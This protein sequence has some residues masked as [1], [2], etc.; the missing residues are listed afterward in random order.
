M[1]KVIGFGLGMLMIGVSFGLLIRRVYQIRK[2]A[3]EMEFLLVKALDYQYQATIKAYRDFKA[4]VAPGSDLSDSITEN[5]MKLQS[6][7]ENY[8]E[9]WIRL[10][11]T[12]RGNKLEKTQIG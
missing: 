11:E 12:Q 7:K 6:V 4:V 9:K 5:I 2:R 3:L 10:L 1:I 8:V